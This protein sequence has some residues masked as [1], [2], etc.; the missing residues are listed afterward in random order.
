MLPVRETRL[1]HPRLS[2][3]DIIVLYSLVGGLPYYHCLLHDIRD[4]RDALYRLMGRPG[5]PLYEEPIQTLREELREPATYQAIL[6][7]IA[8][9]YTTPTRISQYTGIPLPHTSKYLSVLEVLGFIE[10]DTPLF[11]KRGRYRIVDPPLR[12]YY[13][14]LWPLRSLAELEEYDA[15]ISEVEKRLPE[16][17]APTWEDLAR[18]YLLKR[19]ASKGYTLAGRLEHKGLE[20]DAAVL[21][22]REKKAIVGEAKWS[23]LSLAE[24]E[25]IRGRLLRLAEKLLPK[26]YGVVEAY[27]F[28][29]EISGRSDSVE[30]L[31]TP[32]DLVG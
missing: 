30:W 29:R 31:V 23:R 15:L 4:T 18:R 7:A 1:F 14:L 26:E 19:W 13:S 16:Y 6:A 32:G 20:I 21:N 24:A 10:R 12:S 22:P 9:G 3:E 17:V 5:A 8:Q 27:V 25:R 2:P 28:A 11:K